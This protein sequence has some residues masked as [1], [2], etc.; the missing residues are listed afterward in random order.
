LNKESVEQTTFLGPWEG[1]FFFFPLGISWEF[2]FVVV[3]NNRPKAFLW[4]GIGE[5]YAG[6]TI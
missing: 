2:L 5:I 1:I 6:N 4:R 3:E